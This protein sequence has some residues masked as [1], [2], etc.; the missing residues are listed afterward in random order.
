MRISDWSSDVCS[1]DLPGR[2]SGEEILQEEVGAAFFFARRLQQAATILVAD[3]GGGTSDFSLMRFERGPGGMTAT[4][5]GHAGVGVAGDAFDFRIIDN[6]I[7]P[8]LGKG[9]RTSTRLNCSH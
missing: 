1:S 7:A 6:V 3:F 4:P 9:D 5:L 2:P 8:R